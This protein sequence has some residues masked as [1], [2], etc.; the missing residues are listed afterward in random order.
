MGVAGLM[1]FHDNI[2]M[3]I[4]WRVGDTSVESATP[5]AGRSR[6]KPNAMRKVAELSDLEILLEVLVAFAA[7]ALIFAPQVSEY[8]A[9]NQA[10]SHNIFTIGPSAC[11][12]STI[13]S[14]SSFLAASS[15][16]NLRVSASESN[17]S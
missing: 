10:F 14:Q 5:R 11:R 15:S 7:S 17:S 9:G 6:R 12:P 13:C 8:V 3:L 4:V 2:L 16:Y 1:A